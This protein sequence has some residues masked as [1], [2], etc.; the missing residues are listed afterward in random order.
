VPILPVRLGVEIGDGILCTPCFHRVYSGSLSRARQA[1]APAGEDGDDPD[2]GPAPA[3]PA[4]RPLSLALVAAGAGPA[5]VELSPADEAELDAFERAAG[6][7]ADPEPCVVCGRPASPGVETDEGV[8]LCF[9]CADRPDAPPS[10]RSA[11]RDVRF[12]ATC[13]R[14][15]CARLAREL[16]AVR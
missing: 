10:A 1:L 12:A 15:A 9:P 16:A 4:A 11:V 5:W 6:E 14:L 7:T 3:A 13:R 8:L 2:G